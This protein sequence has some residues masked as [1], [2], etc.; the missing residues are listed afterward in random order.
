MLA[1]TIESRRGKTLI[2]LKIISKLQLPSG[3]SMVIK[4]DNSLN[5]GDRLI[6]KEKNVATIKFRSFQTVEANRNK[7]VTVLVDCDVKGDKVSLNKK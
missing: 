5:P 6:D 2:M 3:V 7:L 1:E 4:G